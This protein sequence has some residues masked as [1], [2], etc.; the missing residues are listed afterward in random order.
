MSMLDL[1]SGSIDMT[2]VVCAIPKVGTFG[3]DGLLGVNGDVTSASHAMGLVIQVMK[4]GA[5]DGREQGGG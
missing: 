3:K 1:L 4:A 2:A 5:G